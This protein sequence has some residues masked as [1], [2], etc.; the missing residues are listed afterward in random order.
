MRGHV[1]QIASRAQVCS[2]QAN[3]DCA[4]FGAHSEEKTVNNSGCNNDSSGRLLL[5]SIQPVAPQAASVNGLLANLA[6]PDS[7]APDT[8]KFLKWIS[9]QLVVQSSQAYPLQTLK[10]S[11]LG[12]FHLCFLKKEDLRQARKDVSGPASGL[13]WGARSEK[14]SGP[15]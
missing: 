8:M 10:P 11:L 12:L 9:R 6:V 13:A 7:V 14:T 4:V 2:A 15:S 5:A 1:S 3:L